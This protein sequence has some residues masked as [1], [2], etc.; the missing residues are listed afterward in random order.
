MVYEPRCEHKSSIGRKGPEDWCR[1]VRKLCM[2]Q[3]RHFSRDHL[4]SRPFWLSAVERISSTFASLSQPVLIL[5]GVYGN[6]GEDGQESWETTVKTKDG[7]W[8][9]TCHRALIKQVLPLLINGAPMPHCFAGPSTGH[10][11]GI[12]PA[13]KI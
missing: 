12:G 5:A 13:A 6:N 10:A 1:W 7:M 11:I 9:R 2:P 3:R 4:C 8:P